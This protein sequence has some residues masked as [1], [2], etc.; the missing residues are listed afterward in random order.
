MPG[1]KD[2]ESRAVTL[3][4][5]LCALAFAFLFAGC[6]QEQ[7]QEEGGLALTPDPATISVSSD[8]AARAIEAAGGL[9]AWTK[10][11]ELA[12]DCVV[13]L[14]QPDGSYYLSQ[15][16][17]AI[18]PWSGSI[19]IT[20]REPQGTSVWR[21]SAG[22]FDVLQGSGQI[23]EL[24]A[25][26]PGLCLAEAI[27]NIVTAPVRFLDSS[28]EFSRQDSAVKMKGQWYHPI[29]RQTKSGLGSGERLAKAVFY[30][31]RDNSLIDMIQCACIE[32]GGSLAVRAYDYDEIDK[33]GIL[34]PTK[35]EIFTGDQQG[36]SQ[37]RLVKIDCHK[38]GPA[39]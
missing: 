23:D 34:V 18:Y 31:N 25:A 8:Y 20:A 29:D 27:L 30:Q 22:Q 12:L 38:I 9:D 7:K 13:T 3:R 4:Y 15:Q 26:V 37:A 5:A 16:R 14:Y 39:R 17:Y 6:R 32:T 21:L 35:I 36:A 28:A 1:I 24:S 11:G 10:T 2:Q 33:G 19:Q